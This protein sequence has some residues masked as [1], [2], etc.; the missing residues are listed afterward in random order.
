MYIKLVEIP[1]GWG[2]YFCV[3]NMEIPGR[4]GGDSVVGVWIFSGTTQFIKYQSGQQD[5][6]IKWPCHGLKT[7]NLITC[8]SSVQCESYRG[9][10][11]MHDKL[12]IF[13]M[14]R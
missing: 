8:K 11:M 2:G 3:Q 5:V 1:E 4:R 6:L 10:H 14:Y 7:D 13:S 9:I 12:I